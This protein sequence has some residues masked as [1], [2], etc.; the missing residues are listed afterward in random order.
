MSPPIQSWANGASADGDFAPP[1]APPSRVWSASARAS[2]ALPDLV[3]IADL[4]AQRGQGF[5]GVLVPVVRGLQLG[6]VVI[7]VPADLQVQQARRVHHRTE[8][9]VER[10]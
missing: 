2:R 7:H 5:L 9:L 8:A 6:A 4:L 10:T 3:R 1:T